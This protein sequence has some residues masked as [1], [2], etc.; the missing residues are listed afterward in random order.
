MARARGMPRRRGGPATPLTMMSLAK[1]LKPIVE[2]WA[3]GGWDGVTPT[4]RELLRHWF[5][6]AV[7]AKE[8]FYDCQRRAIETVIYCHEILQASNPLQLYETQIPD[9]LSRFDRIQRQLADVK[10]P[11]Y[12]VKMAT[13]TGKTWVLAALLTWQYSNKR[14]T[15][16]V[17]RFSN[18]FLVVSPVFVVLT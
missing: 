9:L 8:R 2:E 13:G 15:P 16:D 4:T 14:R 6:R 17:A 3:D 10:Y 11:K 18:Y 5:D 1:H 7:D 12:A